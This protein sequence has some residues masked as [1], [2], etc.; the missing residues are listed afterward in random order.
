MAELAKD[1]GRR[2]RTP[3]AQAGV[4][5]CGIAHQREIVRDRLRRNP[6]FL[7]YTLLVQRNA[8][9]PVHLNDPRPSYALGEVLIWRA[10]NHSFDSRITSS[11]H[12][13]C[14]QRIVGLELDHWPDN[15]ACR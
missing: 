2:L 7:D 3:A 1:S 13:C 12:G 15:D 11:D 9:P 8:R 6:K 5:I 10:Q 14:R 4:A